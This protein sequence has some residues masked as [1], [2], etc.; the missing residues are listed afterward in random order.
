MQE[1]VAE[2]GE[3][4]RRDALAREEQRV[5]HFTERQAQGEGRSGEDGGTPEGAGQSRSEFGVANGLGRNGVDGPV[6][7]LI[8]QRKANDGRGFGKREPGHPLP[9]RA[10][11]SP[12]SE[13][14]GQ[15]HAGERPAVSRENHAE[16][17]FDGAHAE[18]FRASGF[19]LPV[20][21]DTRKEIAAGRTV[22]GEFFVAAIA[23]IAD[24]GGRDKDFRARLE[25]RHR[26]DEI[27]RGRDAARTKA[28]LALDGPASSSDGLAGQIDDRF[29]AGS[30]TL[31]LARRRIP[32]NGDSQG[33]GSG[34]GNTIRAEKAAHRMTRAA[35]R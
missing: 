31:E 19:S 6:S 3:A 13:A 10:E 5:C 11:A 16:A 21:G 9:A 18:G 17:K 14:E 30:R 12:E 29:S 24:R 28:G 7:F 8:L 26:R 33:F 15:Q 20:S 25:A 34:A 4:P 27:A 32:A 35:E 22:F 1:A 2:F 23:V